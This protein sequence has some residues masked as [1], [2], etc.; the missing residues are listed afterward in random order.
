MDAQKLK[1]KIEENYGDLNNDAGC[2][3]NGSWLSVKEIVAMIDEC[4]AE[5]N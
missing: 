4:D 2:Y 1:D 3:I 5:D